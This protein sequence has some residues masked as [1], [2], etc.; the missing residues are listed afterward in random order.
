MIQARSQP[1]LPLSSGLRGAL[2]DWVIGASADPFK[3]VSVFS[4]WQLNPATLGVDRM[5]TGVNFTSSRVSGYISYLQEA[6]SSAGG[7]LHSLDIHGEIW[8]TTTGATTVYSIVDSGTWR[9]ND[10]GIVYRDDC[11]RVEVL[12]RRNETFNGTLGPSSSVILRLS[13]ATLANTGYIH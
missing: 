6:N 4:R 13:L 5:E 1:Q 11:I 9:Q 7:R 2:S 8:A 3:G 12:Y 10:I